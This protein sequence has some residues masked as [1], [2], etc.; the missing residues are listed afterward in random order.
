M[1]EH[2]GSVARGTKHANR[3]TAPG[4]QSAETEL[5]DF[6]WGLVRLTHP[7]NVLETGT[8]LGHTTRRLAE[9]VRANGHGLVTSVELDADRVEAVRV[10]L[11]RAGVNHHVRLLHGSYDTV[12]LKPPG[13]QYGVAYFDSHWERDLEYHAARAHLAK[14]A[15]LVFHDCGE[16]HQGGQVRAR[17]ASLEAQ[18]F[19]KGV[20]IPC[21]RGVVV[22]QHA[23][24][25]L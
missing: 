14:G 8:Y 10:D 21:P 9:A 15:L 23:A 20:Y 18:G 19:I 25:A 22:A 3:Y 7:D 12:D 17:V 6:L 2:I 16:Q 24:A 11:M 5:A 13:G 1:H 4:P